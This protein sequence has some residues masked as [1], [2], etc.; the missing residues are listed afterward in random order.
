MHY[1]PARKNPGPGTHPA[2]RYHHSPACTRIHL[3]HSV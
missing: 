1:F 3:R 2:H